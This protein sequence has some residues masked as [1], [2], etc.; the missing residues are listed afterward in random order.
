MMKNQK[1]R[2]DLDD[3]DLDDE[4]LDWRFWYRFWWWKNSGKKKKLDKRAQV[5]IEA[6]KNLEKAKRLAKISSK[7]NCK[8]WWWIRSND[9]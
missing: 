9:I 5:I 6:F 7:R 8:I 4:D 1:K 2:E 3:E